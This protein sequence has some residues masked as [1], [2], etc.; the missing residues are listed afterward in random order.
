MESSVVKVHEEDIAQQEVNKEEVN[1]QEVTEVSNT[2]MSIV[3][4]IKGNFAQYSI[5]ENNV[6][7]YVLRVMTLVEQNKTLS[8]FEKKAVVIEVLTSLVDLSDNLNVNSKA[9]LKIIIKT[10]VPG[11]IESLVS[12]SK[13]ITSLNKKKGGF[14]CC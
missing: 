12:A 4:N 2:I 9:S 7:D 10:I 1:F 14:F 3:K 6:I 8:G 13:G 5:D 11:V